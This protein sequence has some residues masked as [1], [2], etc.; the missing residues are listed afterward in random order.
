[1]KIAVPVQG[2]NLVDNHFGHCA[3]FKIYTV[4]EDSIVQSVEKM[5]SPQGCGCKS[6]L[7]ADFQ[8]I[9]V[10]VLL[11]GG[12]GEGAIRILNAHGVQVVRNCSGDVTELVAGYLTGKIQDGGSSCSAHQDNHQCTNH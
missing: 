6:N 7:A 10:T 5:D 1:M 4:S 3:F 2:D 9:G 12:I 11:A 8:T